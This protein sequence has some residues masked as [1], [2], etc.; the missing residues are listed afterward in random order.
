MAG[1]IEAKCAAQGA[2]AQVRM[3]ALQL[4]QRAFAVRVAYGTGSGGTRI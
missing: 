4:I 3:D 2:D 1:N